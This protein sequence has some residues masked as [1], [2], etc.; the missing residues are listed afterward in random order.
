MLSNFLTLTPIDLELQP[1]ALLDGLMDLHVLLDFDTFSESTQVFFYLIS[2]NRLS[3]LKT[4]NNNFNFSY[5][6]SS[7]TVKI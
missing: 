7:F 5:K 1:I 4:M 6:C 3:F 2:S